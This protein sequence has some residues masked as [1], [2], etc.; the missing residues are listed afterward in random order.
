MFR[1]SNPKTRTLRDRFLLNLLRHSGSGQGSPAACEDQLR[2]KVRI[3]R[4]QYLDNVGFMPLGDGGTKIG[5]RNKRSQLHTLSE[6]EPAFLQVHGAL[7]FSP[8]RHSAIA[9]D[10]A[11]N[12]RLHKLLVT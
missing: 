8:M 10:R 5:M 9:F 7:C 12:M 2:L 11:G 4:E 3:L 1:C 6:H